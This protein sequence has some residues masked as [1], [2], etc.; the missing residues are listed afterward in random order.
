MPTFLSPLLREPDTPHELVNSRTGDVVAHE[1]RTALDSATRRKGLLGL[2]GMPSGSALI[3]APCSAIHTWF[4]RFAIDVV[5]V[6]KDGRV[7]KVRE[8]LNAWR[9]SAALSAHAVVELPA[10][11]IASGTR[12]GD[13]LLLRAHKP[14]IP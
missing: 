4:M 10:G 13:Q 2:D 12:K 11:A 9:M 1:V 8:R 14:R 7:I 5:F 6:A 3:I